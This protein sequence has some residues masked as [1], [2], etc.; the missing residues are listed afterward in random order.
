MLDCGFGPI[1]V[2][3]AFVQ[4]FITLRDYCA[5]FIDN[6]PGYDW[7]H[8]FLKQ[9]KLSLKKGDLM[10]LA[11]KNVTSNLFVIKNFV[12]HKQRKLNV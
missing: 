4:E 1:L 2:V 7:T 11:Q 10:Q 5:R 3:I 9:H 6:R 12:K 8:S